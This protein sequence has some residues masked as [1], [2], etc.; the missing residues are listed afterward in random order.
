HPNVVPLLEASWDSPEPL[1]LSPY[2]VNGDVL[3]YLSLSGTVGFMTSTQI[4]NIAAGMHY[5]H[6][7]RNI[8]HTDLKAQNVLVENDG[9]CRVTDFGT[10][11]ILSVPS[12]GSTGHRAGTAIYMPPERLEGGGATKEGDVYAFAITV[13]RVRGICPTCD[14]YLILM[15]HFSRYGLVAPPTANTAWQTSRFTGT[16]F[17]EDLRPTI[18]KSDKM[19]ESLQQLVKECWDG[20]PKLRPTFEE[21]ARRLIEMRGV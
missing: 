2:M 12:E 5:L 13:Y 17:E 4:H 1:M 8:I 3:D 9:T 20:E 19:S 18:K 7:A 21:V 16:S 11:K 10:S 14:S 6:S 15:F